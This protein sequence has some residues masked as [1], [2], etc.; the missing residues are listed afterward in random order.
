M[1]ERRHKCNDEMKRKTIVD[2][3]APATPP[4][5]PEPKL[6]LE[7]DVGMECPT[8]PRL[9]ESLAIVCQ[10]LALDGWSL[11]QKSVF[12]LKLTQEHRQTLGFDDEDVKTIAVD[13]GIRQG[14]V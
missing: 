7:A 4:P 3:T 14:K 8:T 5:E 12:F 11:E 10:G 1:A 2:E 6:E 9:E 13:A